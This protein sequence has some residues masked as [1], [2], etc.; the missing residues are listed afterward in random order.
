MFFLQII[1]NFLDSKDFLMYYMPPLLFYF[2]KD[3]SKQKQRIILYLKFS[4]IK[5]LTHHSYFCHLIVDM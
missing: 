4:I 3:I 5:K 1:A 2:K